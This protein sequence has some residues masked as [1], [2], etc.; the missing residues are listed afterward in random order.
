MSQR[1]AAVVEGEQLMQLA[2]AADTTKLGSLR[3]INYE[4]IP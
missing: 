2:V 4:V 3:F 1:A